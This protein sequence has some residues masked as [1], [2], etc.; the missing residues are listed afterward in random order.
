MLTT[1]REA[2]CRYS[3]TANT[4]F[5]S[6]AATFT[7]STSHSAALASLTNGTHRYYVRCRDANGTTND[8]DFLITFHHHIASNIIPLTRTR[9]G[10]SMHQ[11]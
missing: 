10:A 9:T 4:A 1:D 3:T 5:D 7:G 2:T 8:D 6:M 11:N